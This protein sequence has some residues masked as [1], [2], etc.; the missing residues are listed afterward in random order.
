MMMKKKQVIVTMLI[1]AVAIAAVLCIRPV[2]AIFFG[3]GYGVTQANLHTASTHTSFTVTE[4]GI[5]RVYTDFLGYDSAVGTELQITLLRDGEEVVSDVHVVRERSHTE[6][7]EY[8]LYEVGEYQC[9][10]VYT[11]SGA[12]G[13]SDVIRFEG[14]ATCTVPAKAVVTN[15][16]PPTEE[17][18]YNGSGKLVEKLVTEYDDKGNRILDT[19]TDGQG[20]LIATLSY[21]AVSRERDGY[22]TL[23][24]WQDIREGVIPL[25][26]AS[27]TVW[28]TNGAKLVTGS[29]V[30]DEQGGIALTIQRTDGTKETRR[31]DENGRILSVTAYNAAQ[32]ITETRRYEYTDGGHICYVESDATPDT[33][34]WEHYDA[35]GVLLTE[36][37]Y[38]RDGILAE[39]THYDASGGITGVEYYDQGGEITR[40]IL[41]PVPTDGERRT[42]RT[43]ADEW[44]TDRDT[45]ERMIVGE[46]EY[47][48]DGV[49]IRMSSYHGGVLFE[50]TF[51]HGNQLTETY[52]RK[53]TEG[54][55]TFYGLDGSVTRVTRYQYAEDGR[56]LG[57]Y[58]YRGTTLLSAV[59]Y[60][61]DGTS[62]T[63]TYRPDGA[64][65]TAVYTDQ[66]G[67][68]TEKRYYAADGSY[69]SS[70]FRY[71][72]KGRISEETRKSMDN[73]SDLLDSPGV[74]T[75][76]IQN[77]AS[78]GYRFGKIETPVMTVMTGKYS[79][80]GDRLTKITYYDDGD[81][82]LALRVDY[83]YGQHGVSEILWYTEGTT[84]IEKQ[85]FRYRA[86][87]TLMS[88]TDFDYEITTSAPKTVTEY[89]SD[90][91]TVSARTTYGRDGKVATEDYYRADGQPDRV[92]FYQN[93]A[94]IKTEQYTYDENGVP[95][96]SQ[97]TAANGTRLA[98][99]VYKD[100]R[101]S[102]E[103]EWV[104]QTVV[105]Y[106]SAGA[107]P[108]TKEQTV[109]RLITYTYDKEGY[110][111]EVRE[112]R[113][114]ALYTV[115]SY[116]HTS[117]GVLNQVI[118][119][120][121]EAQMTCA[122]DACGMATQDKMTVY[123][124][125]LYGVSYAQLQG[126]GEVSTYICRYDF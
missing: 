12:D 58:T 7:Y 14:S 116:Q 102:Y 103:K 71:D 23:G 34:T 94:H 4:E 111:S 125:I 1:V 121:N 53:G 105:S 11:V 93:G 16:F 77:P 44:I 84:L 40:E 117:R 28:D 41:Y 119:K 47:D 20:R 107:K 72:S 64:A 68:I 10:V 101:L 95:L 17:T 42:E 43:Y 66:N 73:F 32:E 18:L 37:R 57:E 96:G 78:K 113:G 52:L 75:T 60:E 8:P 89:A 115:A 91:V 59:L 118:L 5:A 97:T 51:S 61:D 54:V 25:A 82:T 55:R 65:E 106:A 112:E 48:A 45:E 13:T 81:G 90:G 80:N 126:L 120:I 123:N 109:I 27:F 98:E 124:Y 88:M 46:R 83:R 21:H 122:Y 15:P 92:L 9:T 100:G 104:K 36:D 69:T 19:V 87:G 22:Y 74:P 110:L 30:Y 3:G 70:A 76:V 39:R 108:T 26:V 56:A 31:F 50:E 99:R 35:H 62:I 63:L 86:D 114:G 6:V 85:T 67:Q 24:T 49:L 79:Y 2:Y 33:V 38:R 29:Q